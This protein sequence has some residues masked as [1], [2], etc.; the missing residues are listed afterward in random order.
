MIEDVRRHTKN[1]IVSEWEEEEDQR[2]KK[3]GLLKSK[4]NYL[5]EDGTTKCTIIT[6]HKRKIQDSIPSHIGCAILQWSK[7]LFLR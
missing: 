3:G 4:T 2:N 1:S 7:L 6:S 5:G